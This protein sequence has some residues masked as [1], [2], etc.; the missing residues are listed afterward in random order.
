MNEQASGT[1]AQQRLT[2]R[3]S[4]LAVW[5][6]SFGCSVGWGAFVMPG[7][8]FLPIAGP[9]GTAVGIAIGALVML[10]IGVN[11]H[12]LM[13]RFPDAG[14]TFSYS[15]QMFGYDHGFLSSWFM[16]LVYL[17]IIWANA[18]ALPLIFRTLFGDLLQFGF[19]Y[20]IAGYD[21]YAGEILLSLASILV[22]G[23]LCLRGGKVTPTVQILLALIL[24]LGVAASFLLVMLRPEA[25]EIPSFEPAFSPDRMPLG[26]LAFDRLS[27]S[28]GLCGF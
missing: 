5:A 10:V 24:A 9:I 4:P 7:T 15:R 27:G 14:G 2:R 13:N 18:T 19:H 28:V 22:F 1:G 8:T 16:G 25:A 26:R 17:A 12:Y 3:L 6:L 23:G 20:T 21:I 11:Y